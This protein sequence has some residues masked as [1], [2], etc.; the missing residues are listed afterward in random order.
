LGF[1]ATL[2]LLLGFVL[3]CFVVLCFLEKSGSSLLLH[4]SGGK[5]LE[6]EI[7]HTPC[8]FSGFEAFFKDLSFEGSVQGSGDDQMLFLSL[9]SK[10]K[11]CVFC[12]LDL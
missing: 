9:E 5:S 4:I 3:F 11:S 8:F 7:M 10:K 1:E 12:L 6:E 2:L